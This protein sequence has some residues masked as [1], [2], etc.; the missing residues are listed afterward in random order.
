VF[1]IDPAL[2]PVD[3]TPSEAASENNHIIDTSPN[4]NHGGNNSN[5]PNGNTNSD[6]NSSNNSDLRTRIT[7]KNAIYGLVEGSQRGGEDLR[8]FNS[9]QSEHL[10]LNDIQPLFGR[11]PYPMLCLLAQ[12]PPPGSPVS[13][14]RLLLV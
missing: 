8:E 9:T 12:L 7:A 5:T 10:W 6:N 3:V 11:I 14:E 4:L 1:Q 2:L 13:S